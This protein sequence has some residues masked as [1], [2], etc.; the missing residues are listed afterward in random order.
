MIMARSAYRHWL[1][2][3]CLVVV[4]IGGATAAPPPLPCEFSGDI[5]IN[6]DPAPAGTVITAVIGGSDR[7]S[8]TTT[9]SGTYGGSE[10][11]EQNLFV[12]GTETEVGQTITF[13]VDG[14]ETRETAT[15]T[16]GA[17]QTLNLSATIC[18]VA[19]T[20]PAAAPSRIPTDTDGTPGT[21]ETATLSVSVAG[22]NPIASV[23]V[24]FSKIGG[25]PSAPMA[26]AGEGTWTVSTT[27]TIPSAFE[28]GVYQ[29][30]FLMVNATDTNGNSNTTV[31]IP[32]TVVKNGDVNEDYKVTLY[33]AVYTARHALDIEGYAMTESVGEVSGDGG[34]S[35]HDAMYL[36]RY[37][38]GIPGYG[39]LH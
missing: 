28:D 38:L 3:F 14:A 31:A 33:D 1:L 13:R 15:F 8:L 10:W 2:A 34:L 19:V 37:V 21:G 23:T 16:P 5:N 24:N 30:S 7:G 4:C 9:A 35:L 32:L 26:D 29:P 12:Q 6:G 27:G 20:D 25:S 22:E 17:I 39:T 36:A 18:R 11:W